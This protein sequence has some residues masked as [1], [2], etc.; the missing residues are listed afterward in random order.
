METHDWDDRLSQLETRAGAARAMGGSEKLAKR[1]SG[2]AMN[3][4]QRV[5]ALFDPG[6][7]NEI[8]LL[9]GGVE[10][11]GMGPTPADAFVSGWGRIDGRPVLAGVE[12]FTVQ[13]GSI[14][15]ATHA[16]RLRI[17][18]L[19]MQERL[20]LV[21][22]LEGAGERVSNTLQRYPYAPNDLQMLADLSG[23]VPTVTGV[24]GP[25]A[26]HGALSGVLADFVVMVESASLF[27]AGPPLVAQAIGEEV[28]KEELGGAHMH[29]SESGVVHNVAADDA[30]A[31]SLIRRYLGYFG[32]NAWER[33]PNTSEGDAGPRRLEDILDVVPR[34]VTRGYDMRDVLAL[35]VDVDSLFEYQPDFGGS[36]LTAL[37]R[38]GGRPVAIVAN[39]PLLMA[40]AVTADAADKAARFIELAG[41]FHLPVVFL[42]DN[43]GIMSGTAAERAG[44]LRSAAR[45]YAAQSRLRSPKLHVTMRKA[46]GFGSSLM[47]MN[48]FDSQTV[49]LAFPGISLG[50]LPASGGGTAAKVAPEM[51]EMLDAAEVEAAWKVADN[52]SYDEVIDPRDLRNRLLS[53]LE[54]TAGRQAEPAA[55]VARVGVLP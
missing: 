17:A 3:A 44:T 52:G 39:Q 23:F 18:S 8:Q 19:A 30:E 35:L 48:P 5:E 43:P 53:A 4:R 37:G 41:A 55:P 34:K 49:T 27:S 6:T 1:A 45:M 51:Q 26:G 46:Y 11:P 28:T 32:S 21:L 14:G 15:F 31:I 16:K 54:L 10:Q 13:G 38:L 47:A 24:M 9:A 50:G 40:G 29:A 25:S 22:L 42:T 20:P 2:G 36:M 7:F 33:P 12:D